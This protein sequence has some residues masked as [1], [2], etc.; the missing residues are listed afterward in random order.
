MTVRHE[1]ENLIRRGNIFYWRP[2][3]PKTFTRCPAGS[4]LSLSLQASDHRKA[5][6]LARRLNTLLAD[7]KYGPQAAMTD[8]EQLAKLFAAERDRMLDQLEKVALMARRRGRPDDIQD[9]EMDIENG[10]AA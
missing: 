6:V 5:Q 7:L 10:W 9:V 1:V 3:I 4:R 8:K 2:R